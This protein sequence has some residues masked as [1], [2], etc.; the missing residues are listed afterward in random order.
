[1]QAAYGVSIC[2]RYAHDTQPAPPNFSGPLCQRFF[3]EGKFL[4]GLIT[5][6]ALGF[7]VFAQRR[8]SLFLTIAFKLSASRKNILAA[9]FSDRA[10]IACGIYKV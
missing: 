9:R 8:G 2:Y 3:H 10:G 5:V 4:L 1:M 7:G 6:S